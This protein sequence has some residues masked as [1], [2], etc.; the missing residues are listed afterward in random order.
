MRTASRVV[1]FAV[2]CSWAVGCNCAGSDVIIDGEGGGHGGSNDGGTKG[3]GTGGSGGSA[4]GTSATGGSSNGGGTSVDA[5][6][7]GPDLSTCAGA[8]EAKSYV[9]CDYWP[10]VVANNVWSIFDYAVVVANA[11]TLPAM[12][13]ITGPNAFSKT[14]MVQPGEIEKFY[15]PWVAS[16]KGQ[17]FN[18]ETSAVAMT[19]S[20]VEHGGAYHLVSTVPVTVYQFNALEYGPQ[21]GPMGKSWASCPG[22]NGVGC[23]S[24]SNDASLLLPSTA[25]TGN[26]RVMGQTGLTIAGFGPVMGPYFAI[27]VTQNGTNV[28][29]KTTAKSVIL[30][31]GGVPAMT[32][33][34]QFML[35]GL[36]AGDVVEVVGDKGDTVDFSGSLVTATLPVQVIS[37]VPCMNQPETAAACD[38]IEESVFP[39]ETLGEHYVVTVPTSPLGNVVGH[40]VRFYGNVDGTT[41]TYLPSRPGT[42]PA[43]LSAGEVVDCGQIVKDFEVTG[44]NAFGVGSFM[45]GGTLVDPNGGEGDPSQSF[46]VAVEQYRPS[47]IFLAPND[48]DFSFVDI[49]GPPTVS[50]TIDG[51]AVTGFTAIDANFSVARHLLAAGNAGSHTLNATAPVGIQVM[52][53]GKYTSY[54]YPGGSN[55]TA[56]APPPIN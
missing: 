3:G 48:Y 53:Y 35:S 13:T 56:I 29:V 34:G 30:A 40:L 16:L 22:N 27:T 15:L 5:G 7:G 32:G 47:Y 24:Y 21:G 20:V 52:G 44:N 38:H 50:V 55:L 46:S 6:G 28:T 33:A 51:V 39:A 45:L 17:D 4:G 49:V 12:V 26:Y 9:G 18:A 31:G 19:A 41:L 54:Q 2:A 11:G 25:M 23:F 8:A 37:G 1:V 10:T 14:D 42:C 43:T 36:N